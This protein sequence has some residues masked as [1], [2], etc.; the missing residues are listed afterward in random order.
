[1]LEDVHFEFD[2]AT[3]TAEAKAIL[4]RDIAVLKDN[5]EVKVTVEGHTCAHGT[6]D[7]NMRLGARRA[8]A[9]KEFLVKEGGIDPARMTTI[10]YGKTRQAMPEEPTPTNQNS[11]D[12]KANRRVHFE[13]IVQ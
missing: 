3:L 2:K 11:P 7:Y 8:E 13:V 6:A 1:V 10:S 5:P 12:M 9:V 4:L